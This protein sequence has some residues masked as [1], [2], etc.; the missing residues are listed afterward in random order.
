MVNKILSN[1]IE[2]CKS[3]KSI[4]QHCYDTTRDKEKQLI[5]SGQLLELD[6]MIQ[7]INDSLKEDINP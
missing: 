7:L 5:F 3:R 4:I 6:E 1:M 2:Y